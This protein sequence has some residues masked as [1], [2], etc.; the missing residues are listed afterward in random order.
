[1]NPIPYG[2]Q[3]ITEEDIIAVVEAL[4]SD[5]LTQGPKILDFEVEFAKY[6]GSKYAVAVSNGTAALHLSAM[7]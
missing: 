1:M 3:N 7:A 6:I 2:R 5:Y 4:K